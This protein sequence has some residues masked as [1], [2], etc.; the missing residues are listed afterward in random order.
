MMNADFSSF[1]FEK[2]SDVKRNFGMS[3]LIFDNDVG[4]IVGLIAAGVTYIVCKKQKSYD[5]KAIAKRAA[6]AFAIGDLIG[7][8]LAEIVVSIIAKND[9]IA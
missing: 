5:K 4:L 1:I 2:W 9:T 7:F 6:I 3:R 8:A